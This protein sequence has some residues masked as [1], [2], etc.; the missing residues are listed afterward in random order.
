[1]QL[2]FQNFQCGIRNRR[3]MHGLEIGQLPN[4]HKPHIHRYTAIN[5]T[6]LQHRKFTLLLNYVDTVTS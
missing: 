1:M 2:Q 4:V 3:T 6:P 5:C